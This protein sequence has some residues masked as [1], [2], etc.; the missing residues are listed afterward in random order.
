MSSD[1]VN[2][3]RRRF[4]IATTSVVGGVGAG[5]ATVPFIKSFQPSAKAQAVGAPVEVNIGKLEQGQLLKVQWRGQ[6]IGILRRSPETL[7]NLDSVTAELRDPD[8]DE[9]DQPEYTSNTYRALEPEFLVVNMH[10]THLGCV[11]QMIPQVGPQP[12]DENW[13]GGFY[14]PC[15]KSKFDSAGRVYKAVP[16]P[17]NLK[18][19]PYSFLDDRTLIIGVNPEGAA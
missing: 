5:L 15:H 2:K 10:C 11:P 7:E 8:S 12:F 19:P 16:A 3:D 9:S 6:T 18:I 1:G 14:C 4:L 13:K 17:T